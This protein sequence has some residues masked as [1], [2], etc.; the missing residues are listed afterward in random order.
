M[1]NHKV[2]NCRKNKGKGAPFSEIECLFEKNMVQMRCKLAKPLLQYITTNVYHLFYKKCEKFHG[3]M[4][5]LKCDCVTLASTSVIKASMSATNAQ[6]ARLATHLTRDR[7]LMSLL[8][9]AVAAHSLA[10]IV[11]QLFVCSFL[12]L[13]V[14]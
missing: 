10:L 7:L 2:L 9:R 5:S 14:H 13:I 1:K 6:A 12:K 11:V 8:L 4:M 3:Q